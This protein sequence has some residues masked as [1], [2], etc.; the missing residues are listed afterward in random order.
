[1]TM[2]VRKMV[3]ELGMSILGPISLASGE[4]EWYGVS[5]EQGNFI[6]EEMAGKVDREV[7]KILGEAY[8]QAKKVL[9]KNLPRMEKVT[10]ALLEKETLDEEEFRKLVG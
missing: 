7:V 3:M 1:A 2:I 10:N 4:M 6:S 5:H 9:E 8:V